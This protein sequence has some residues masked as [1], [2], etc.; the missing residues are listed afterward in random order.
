MGLKEF[1]RAHKDLMSAIAVILVFI[2]GIMI[3]TNYC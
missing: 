3:G 2:G 1:I